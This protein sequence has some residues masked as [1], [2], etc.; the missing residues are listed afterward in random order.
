MSE[1][2][3]WVMLIVLCV[4]AALSGVLEVLFVP[5]YVGSVLVPVV[6]PLAIAGNLLLP[7]LG[8]ALVPTG[9]GTLAPV[10]SWLA[11]VLV[12]ALFPRR[13][14]DVLVPGG[15]G[16]QWTFYG[17]LLGGCVAGFTSLVLSSPPPAARRG[18]AAPT[19]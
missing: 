6:V 12:L 13:E 15:G 7:R 5:L 18:R 14:G 17:L 16:P 10:L 11:P 2:R 8:R 1:N 4:G 19:R 3:D 9:A